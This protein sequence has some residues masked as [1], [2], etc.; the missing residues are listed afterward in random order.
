VDGWLGG[1]VQGQLEHIW[2]VGEIGEGVHVASCG[3][4][5]V[6]GAVDEACEGFSQAG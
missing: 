5:P 4:E 3:Y 2:A 1:D 6:S